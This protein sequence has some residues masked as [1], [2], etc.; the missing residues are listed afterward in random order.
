MPYQTNGRRNYKKEYQEY[1]SRPEQR[2]NRSKRTVARNQAI[3]EGRVKRGD[4]KDLD[5][6]RP[7]SKGG[8]NARSNT[9]VVSASTN[10]SFS[11]NADGSIKSQTS[12]RERSKKK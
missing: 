4:S 6:V 2:A 3:E 7:L 5:H 1:H 12:K 8:S 11:R 10:R 9:R